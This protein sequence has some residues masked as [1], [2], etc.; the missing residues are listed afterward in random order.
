M[1]PRATIEEVASTAGVSR[2]TVSRVVNGS[3]AVSPEAL[4]AVRAAIDELNYVPNRAARS[5]ASRQTHAIALIVPEDTTRFF[6]D[7]F[8]AAI[9]AG[10]TGA[11]GGSDY[12]L[13]LLIASDDPGDKMTSFVRNGG[14]DGAL[15]VSHHTS[16]AFIDRIADAVPVVFGGRPVRRHE[17][18]YVVDVDNVA[19]AKNA[20]QR[21]IDIGRTRIA[22]IS[23]PLTMVASEDRVQG[24]RAALAEAGLAPYAEEE[25]DYSESSGAEA[26]RRLL[27][28]GRPDAIFVA[29]DLMA[30]GALT[31]LRSAGVRV[32]EDIALVGFDDSSVALTTDPQL[33][34][35]RQPMYAQGEAMARVLL[36]RLAGEEPPTTTILPTELVIRASA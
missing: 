20:T 17:G 1:S 35:M 16:D 14:V 12:L 27:D 28:G 7:P 18:D 24:F 33:T 4:A 25:G 11:L 19:G 23:G 2:S 3:T 30:R 29:S 6:G 5:L 36:S 34:T 22:T 15:I 8:F 32:P 26:A 10:I 9:V 21:L 31:A 13:N